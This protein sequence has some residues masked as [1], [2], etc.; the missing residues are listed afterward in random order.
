[1]GCG[2]Q[3]GEKQIASCK[4]NITKFFEKYDGSHLTLEFLDTIY[5]TEGDGEYVEWDMQGVEFEKFLCVFEHRLDKPIEIL[6]DDDVLSYW[7]R[8]WK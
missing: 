5:R 8:K 6:F 1:M 2:S 4:D 7:E 3:E